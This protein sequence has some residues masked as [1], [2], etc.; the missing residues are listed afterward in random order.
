MFALPEKTNAFMGVL[1]TNVSD[2]TAIPFYIANIPLTPLQQVSNLW[3]M[4]WQSIVM[5]L[6][7][8]LA[9]LAAMQLIQNIV[10]STINWIRSGFQGSPSFV[11]NP[12]SLLVN[13]ADQTIGEMIFR[14]P[15]LNFLCSPFQ[16]Q[17]KLALG[18]QFGDFSKKINCT[19]SG[20]T[21]NVTNAIN[22]ASVSINGSTVFSGNKF[23]NSGGWDNWIQTTSQPQ[24]NSTGAFLIAKSE[25]DERIANKKSTVN[26]ELN[27]GQGAMSFKS[28]TDTD[29]SVSTGKQIGQPSKTYLGSPF[30]QHPATSSLTYS[31]GS[32]PANTNGLALTSQIAGG[33]GTDAIRKTNC[34]VATPGA[35]ITNQLGFQAS[36]NQRMGEMQAALANG[37]DQIL[38]ALASELLSMTISSLTNGI[39][40]NNSSENSDYMSSLNGQFQK[41][42]QDYN[43]Q[44]KKIST[45]TMG[46][47]DI[48][49]YT[50]TY[51]QFA[52]QGYS[53]G[54]S[55]LNNNINMYTNTNNQLSGQ[56]YSDLS[57]VSTST[58]NPT[59]EFINN[60][61]S[62][63]S[64]NT[65][66]QNTS[67][68]GASMNPINTNDPINIQKQNAV[69]RINYL[70]IAE[71]KFQDSM[72]NVE[73]I[74]TKG[75]S[76]FVTAKNCNTKYNSSVSKL[77]AS[78]ID[79]NVITNIDGAKNI[80][81][82]AANIPWNLIKIQ[83]AASSSKMNMNSLSIARNGV[84]GATSS[85][86]II[87]SLTPITSIQF[88]T[89]PQISTIDNVST[90]IRGVGD[91][92]TTNYCPINLAPVF[93]TSTTQ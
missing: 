40:G 88:N 92:Y 16:L 71:T 61:V 49:Q 82:T 80:N 38:S 10:Q 57:N 53:N 50:N 78:L 76:V 7:Q 24:N 12:A 1:D 93:S 79:A 39:L 87:D 59:L 75:K 27:W 68:S 64:I 48:S 4:S 44:I 11:G 8:T 22:N 77:R 28:C 67:N 3:Q 74:L 47:I 90:W 69:L 23:I 89:D 17:V 51:D 45:T 20:V 33:G 30:M 83:T 9:K 32:A 86:G 85:K 26:Q 34:E 56:D 72:T 14:D 18:L 37:L 60:I 19:L 21:N 36:S 41:A 31:D 42:Q 73:N 58:D 25:L 2:V 62:T 13:T 66:G 46:N 91:L 52:G 63:D 84:S 29:F 5:K 65:I 55:N 54:L 35:I 6:L 15:A 70:Q 81:R 43:N